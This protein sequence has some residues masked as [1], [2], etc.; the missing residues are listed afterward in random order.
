MRSSVQQF[1]EN[2][3]NILQ[4]VVISQ[5]INKGLVRR[6]KGQK[7]LVGSLKYFIRDKHFSM[8][9]LVFLT[10]QSSNVE[11]TGSLEYRANVRHRIGGI[12]LDVEFFTTCRTS[13]S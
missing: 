13:S 7:K 3:T 12:K 2:G 1:N 5:L 4:S 10:N 11:P 6:E 9:R 8:T